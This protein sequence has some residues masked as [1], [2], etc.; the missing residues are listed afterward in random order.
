[1]AKCKY[2]DFDELRRQEGQPG[3][4]GKIATHH[5]KLFHLVARMER[6]VVLEFGVDKGRSTCVLLAACEGTGGHLYSVDIEDCSQVA[7]SEAWTFIRQSDQEIEAIL[8]QASE[9]ALGIDLL[10]I[11]SLH[12]RAHVQQLLM[13]WF[14]YVKPGGYITFHDV[15]P[16]PYLPGQRKDNPRHE[17]E[18]IGVAQVIREFFYANEDQLFLEY[19]FGSTGMGIMRK[20][21]PL[22]AQ[23]NPPMPLR[24][25]E[26]VLSWGGVWW[27]T[28]HALRTVVKQ[29]L[30]RWRLLV[31]SLES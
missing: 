27:S 2:F 10:H 4:E 16:T 30:G 23:P 6:P 29:G 11:D 14:P 25:R 19:H 5:M 8:E 13:K 18:A 1:M 7:D 28:R 26:L 24:T 22:G 15:D 31:T 9:L 20:L 3:L 17:P 12:R 21:A